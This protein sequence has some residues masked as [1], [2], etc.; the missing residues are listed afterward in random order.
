MIYDSKKRERVYVVLM[1]NN[2]EY[3]GVRKCVFYIYIYIYMYVCMHNRKVAVMYF[4]FYYLLSS[5][6]VNKGSCI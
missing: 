4:R 3:I 5:R 6:N 2:L 1:I